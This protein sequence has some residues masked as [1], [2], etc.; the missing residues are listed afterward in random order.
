MPT[1]IT[2]TPETE[3]AY[4][5]A[6]KVLGLSG[7]S[8]IRDPDS[9]QKASIARSMIL[10]LGGTKRD[11]EAGRALARE[12]VIEAAAKHLARNA[13]PVAAERIAA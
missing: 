8:A 11:P 6:V 9:Y 10:G 2:P 12:A 1:P 5:A 13:A 7:I 4:L 3:A